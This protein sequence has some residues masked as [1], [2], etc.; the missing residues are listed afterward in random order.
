MENDGLGQEGGSNP[1]PSATSKARSLWYQFLMWM[2]LAASTVLRYNGR[3]WSWISF[4]IWR[5]G[6][7]VA[8][9][10]DRVTLYLYLANHVLMN[11]V[12]AQAAKAYDN[13]HGV[14]YPYEIINKSRLR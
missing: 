13:D 2:G 5:A 12:E 10:A 3:A 14:K 1:P 6:Q 7:W 4:A 11:W 8:G 9:R